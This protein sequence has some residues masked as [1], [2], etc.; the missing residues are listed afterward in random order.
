M[1]IRA[2][3]ASVALSSAQA[4]FAT[5]ISYEAEH[6]GGTDSLGVEGILLNSRT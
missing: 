2:I 3:I 5:G 6:I 4:S 1:S